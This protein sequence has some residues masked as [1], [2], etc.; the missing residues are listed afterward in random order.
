[1]K[2][3]DVTRVDPRALCGPPDHVKLK[4]QAR[5]QSRPA[6][7]E[8]RVRADSLDRAKGNPRIIK[9]IRDVRRRHLKIHLIYGTFRQR[10]LRHKIDGPRLASSIEHLSASI[11]RQLNLLYMH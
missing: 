9:R 3:R 6:S 5:L 8:L 11:G 10:P 1:M 7:S 2:L 4:S